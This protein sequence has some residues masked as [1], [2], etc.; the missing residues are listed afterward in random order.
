MQFP[1]SYVNATAFVAE[2]GTLDSAMRPGFRVAAVTLNKAGASVSH[3]NFAS[4]WLTPSGT[5]WG[6]SLHSLLTCLAPHIPAP[7]MQWSFCPLPSG[8]YFH[9]GSCHKR[10]WFPGK[11][12]EK[13]CNFAGRRWM[14]SPC[15]DGSLLVSDDLAGA[16]YRMTFN[17]TSALPSG[18]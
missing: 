7:C 17:K 2:H 11:Y 16:V 6:A 1:K 10:A 18:Y 8:L 12:K 9:P 3:I 15:W 4:G 13:A 5:P 14:C